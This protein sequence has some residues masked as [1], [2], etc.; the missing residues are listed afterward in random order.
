M[1]VA[2]KLEGGLGNQMFQ[3]TYG[4]ALSKEQD[5]V[6]IDDCA[7]YGMQLDKFNITLPV[8]PR[9]TQGYTEH[10]GYWHSDE[11]FKRVESEIREQ[12]TPKHTPNPAAVEA[13]LRIQDSNSVS[14]H[15]RRGDYTGPSR[16]TA[17]IQQEFTLPIDYYQRALDHMQHR[18]P[19]PTFFFFSDEIDWADANIPQPRVCTSVHFQ[20]HEDLWLMS[21]CKHS[22]IANSTLSWWGARLNPSTDRQVIY[23]AQWFPPHTLDK[24]PTKP[25]WWIPQ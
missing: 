13:S 2:V 11:Y 24:G 25:E 22:I 18:L 4:Y 17:A 19:F 20:P 12:F 21:Q 8:L 23:P 14:V 10:N 15:I 16:L 3:Y 5:V 7:H 6:F 9:G 1:T